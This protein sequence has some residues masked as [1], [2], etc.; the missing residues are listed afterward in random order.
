MTIGNL[1]DLP[2]LPTGISHAETTVLPATGSLSH[3]IATSEADLI[4][5]AAP[6][7]GGAHYSP[8]PQW[9]SEVLDDLTDL[10]RRPQNWDGYGA[11]RVSKPIAAALFRILL[12]VADENTPRPIVYGTSPGG[13]GLEWET[14]HYFI[15]LTCEPRVRPSVYFWDQES[16]EEWDSPLGEEPM[17]L[18]AALRRLSAD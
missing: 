6:W 17:P 11:K 14:P 8:K 2:P 1:T 13:A 16:G 9:T 7:R 3:G 15:R 5:V 10:I 12:G 18:R 4:E